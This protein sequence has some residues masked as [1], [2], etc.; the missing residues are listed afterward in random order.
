MIF[1]DRILV[2]QGG[3][4]LDLLDGAAAGNGGGQPRHQIQAQAGMTLNGFG[5]RASA[6]WQSGTTV[7]GGL[8]SPTGALTFSS[9]AVV[10]LRLFANLGG[11]PKVVEHRPWLRGTRVTLSFNNLFDTRERVR[12]ATG[13][14]PVSYQQAYLDP[15]GR[16]V[17][18][19]IRKLFF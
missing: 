18:L 3:P 4:L 2:R 14:T 6:S 16:T 11:M 8:A 5:A 1:D 19:D 13:A 10:N 7:R 12:D 17:H 15:E 9:L